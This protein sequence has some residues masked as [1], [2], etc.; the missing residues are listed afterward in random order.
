M[1][2]LNRRAILKTGAATAALSVL[3]RIGFAQEGETE[4]HGL[5]SFGELKYPADFPYFDYV[6]RPPRAAAGSRHS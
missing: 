6:D 4:T 1:T 2:T 3:P 5:S